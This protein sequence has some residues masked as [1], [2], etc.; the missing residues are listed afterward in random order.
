LI[1]MPGRVLNI[2]AMLCVPLLFGLV[3]AYCGRRW[4]RV[5]TIGLTVGLLVGSPTLLPKLAS[6]SGVDPRLSRMAVL[7]V[8]ALALIACRVAEAISPASTR[9][10]VETAPSLLVM[11]AVLAIVT[12]LIVAMSGWPLPPLHA[13][14]MRDRLNDGLLANVASGRGLLLTGG[15]LHLIQLRTRRPVLLDGG[16]LDAL[17]YALEGA[18]AMDRILRDVYGVD[19]FT[20]PADAPKTGVVPAAV[21]QQVWEQ[22]SLERWQQLRRTYQVT[23][24]LTPAG[25]QLKLPIV[26][27]DMYFRLHDIPR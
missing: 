13:A 25:W 17:P 22:Y 4:G 19:L 14:A 7:M 6:L 10:R 15:D 21:N 27:Q 16:G 26:A 20:P 12:V 9:D 3:G 8:A 11:N 2:A 24:V 23:Q 5:I 1:L 18:P